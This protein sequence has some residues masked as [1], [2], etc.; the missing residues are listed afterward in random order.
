MSDLT[1]AVVEH[2]AN[3]KNQ[4]T[5]VP[6]IK[7]Y[8]PKLQE[9]NP[10]ARGMGFDKTSN[11]FTKFKSGFE[12]YEVLDALT[13]AVEAG[14]IDSENWIA[15]VFEDTSL[16]EEFLDSL[17]TDGIYRLHDRWCL[18]LQ[19]ITGD[20]DDEYWVGFH[21]AADTLRNHAEDTSQI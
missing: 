7:P 3:S 13:A 2:H 1:S 20:V 19:E 11:S 18:A 16:F 8:A 6:I 14:I 9:I 17:P 21:E 5:A 12:H 10:M 15:A 4:G